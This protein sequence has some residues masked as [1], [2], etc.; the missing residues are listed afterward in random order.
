MA[1]AEASRRSL[2]FE[3]VAT[4]IG[5]YYRSGKTRNELRAYLRNLSRAGTKW[6]SL[7]GDAE[8]SFEQAFSSLAYT[9]LKDKAPKLIDYLVGFQLVDRNEDNTKAVGLFGI[10]LGDEWLYAPVF[11]LNGELKGHELLYIKKMDTFV[12]MKENWV[13]YLMARK[14]H[15][16]GEG[17]PQDAYQLGGLAPDLTRLSVLPGMGKISCDAWARPFLPFLAAM[18]TD[19]KRCFAKHASLA[20]DLDLRAFIAQDVSLAGLALRIAETYPGIKRAFDQFY[21]PNFLREAGQKLLERELAKQAN[22][23]PPAPL[24]KEAPKPKRV[25]SS[26]IPEED[27][28]AKQAEE[29]DKQRTKLKLY[30]SASLTKNLPELDDNERE[31]LLTDGKLIKDERDPHAISEVYDTQTRMTLTNPQET[32]LY[33]VLERP[34]EFGRMLV[35]K[36]P[37]SNRGREDFC[38]VVRLD[39]G[40]KA[41]MNGHATKIWQRKIEEPSEYRDWWDKLPDSKSL[42]KGAVYM[43]IGQAADASVPFTVR[44]K[45]DEDVYRVDYDAYCSYDHGRSLS[46][47]TVRGMSN[48]PYISTYAALLRVNPRRGTQMRAVSGELYVPKSYKFLKLKEPPKPRKPESGYLMPLAEA[49]GP[50]GSGSEPRPIQPGTLDDIQLLFSEKTAA[51]KLYA[52]GPTVHIETQAR[53]LE[54]FDKNG[55]LFSLVRDHGVREK[56]AEAMLDRAVTKGHAHFRIKYADMYGSLQGGPNAPAVSAPYTGVEFNGPKSVQSIYPQEEFLP[57]P[58]LQA[59]QT[60]PQIYDPWMNFEINHNSVQHA[61]QAAQSGQKE[62]FDAS[63]ISGLLKSVRQDSLVDKHLP[64]L[65]KCVDRLGRLLF[66]YFWHQEEFA[67]RYGKSEL[68]ELEDGLRN[69]FE[70]LGDITLFL[71]QK[72][73]GDDMG[74]QHGEPDIDESARN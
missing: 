34:T 37:H 26:L 39:D 4:A 66:L 40:N 12:P 67:E 57:V 53:G 59:A 46:M 60:N 61:Q 21:G 24:K 45:V 74:M 19:Y 50:Y 65:M 68:P 31:R 13:N 62:V 71:K 72:T 52:D 14:P 30:D 56:A 42:D 73:V 51:L 54:R 11:F 64:I 15:I 1:T 8:G 23:L 18:A 16:L 38:T 36:N 7:G 25:S 49:D 43:A 32:G 55:A 70:T 33:E 28:A 69:A 20:Q 58:G 2:S 9:Y 10:Q 3:K 47:P 17:S 6:A 29:V 27:H 22:I 63:M 5:V 41:W 35:V 48:E 44:D